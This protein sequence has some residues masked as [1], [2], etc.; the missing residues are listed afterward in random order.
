[1]SNAKAVAAVH[2]NDG[3]RRRGGSVERSVWK[4]REIGVRCMRGR[5]PPER[6]RTEKFSAAIQERWNS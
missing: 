2:A 4:T 3:A 5:Y 6:S 1:M